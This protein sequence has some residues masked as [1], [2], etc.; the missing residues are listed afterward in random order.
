M[1]PPPKVASTSLV[2][3]GLGISRHSRG[4]FTATTPGRYSR[5]SIHAGDWEI[6]DGAVSWTKTEAQVLK[7]PPY[8]I[9]ASA[10]IS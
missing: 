3:D 1:S 4:S 7:L 8:P 6:I 10:V 5:G 2:N 9:I